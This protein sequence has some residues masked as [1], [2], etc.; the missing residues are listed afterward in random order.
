MTEERWAGVSMDPAELWKRWYETSMGVWSNVLQQGQRNYADPYGLY[1]QW[2]ETVQDLQESVTGADAGLAKSFNGASS[3]VAAALPS[4]AQQELW[5]K[6]FDATV[7]SWQKS[8][9]LG[10]ETVDLTPRWLEMLEQA[11]NNLLSLESFPKDPLEFAVQWYNA[12][13]GP[14][15]EFVQDVVEREEFLEASSR[16]MQNYASLYRIFSR[17]SEEYLRN[18]QIPVRSDISRIAG[19]IVALEDKVDRI[20]EA[21][22]DFEDGYAKPATAEEVGEL[23]KRPRPRR[24]QARP[25]AH[26]A[27][28]RP[29]RE[30]R[31]GRSGGDPGHRRRPAQGARA[32][33]RPRRG[34]RDRGR[35][36]DHGRRRPAE[37]RQL[38]DGD[39]QLRRAAHLGRADR[40]A[41][42]RTELLR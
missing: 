8:I 26:G 36:P 3:G 23:D 16:W 9:G 1:R 32:R 5:G 27:R 15:G 14:F 17:Q 40:R 29:G 37:G 39:R 10:Q 11:R 19:L 34:K 30:W 31:L 38:D 18:L 35:R 25:A 42:G 22:E 6:F 12:T 33:R 7:E 21:F 20:E 4:A 13:N 2:F 24:R 41:V 28:K